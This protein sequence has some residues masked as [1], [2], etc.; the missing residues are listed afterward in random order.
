MPPTAEMT[1]SPLDRAPA[2]PLA[3]LR[4]TPQKRWTA[5]RFNARTLS[6]D[7]RMLLWNTLTGAVGV[8]MGNVRTDQ[9]AAAGSRAPSTTSRLRCSAGL[10]GAS[11]TARSRSSSASRGSP[12]DRRSPARLASTSGLPPSTAIAAS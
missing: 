1:A 2:P 8:R 5:S 9:A 11:A 4:Y 3:Q 12:S 6:D 10:S 7:G